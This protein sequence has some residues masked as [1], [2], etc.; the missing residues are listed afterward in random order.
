MGVGGSTTNEIHSVPPIETGRVCLSQ[1]QEA[2]HLPGQWRWRLPV[3]SPKKENA[4][5]LRNIRCF[6]YT[7]YKTLRFKLYVY[8]YILIIV[9]FI[10]PYLEHGLKHI[11]WGMCVD[12]LKPAVL[13]VGHPSANG[14][15]HHI[16]MESWYKATWWR[17]THLVSGV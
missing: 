15:F 11:V 3:G 6:M 13:S 10:N 14:F 17:T 12:G 1:R 5:V 16:A 8:I 9:I 7:L 2:R 4:L